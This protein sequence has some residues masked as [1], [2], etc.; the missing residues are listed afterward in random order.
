MVA[1]CAA[2]SSSSRRTVSSSSSLA[3][4]RH[5]HHQQHV[6]HDLATT[7]NVFDAIDD[8]NDGVWFSSL[9]E[10]SSSLLSSSSSQQRRRSFLLRHATLA[11]AAV[12][13]TTTYSHHGLLPIQPALA[14][15]SSSSSTTTT[16]K[17]GGPSSLLGHAAPDFELPN[18]QGQII[19]L[20]TL[21]SSGTKWA[22]LYF[23]P[24]AFTTGCTLEARKF[25]EL[26]PQFTLANAIISGISVD[27]VSTNTEFCNSE[28]LDFYLLS[29]INNG[30]ISK[31]Y[32]TALSVPMI[33][34][35]ANRQTYIIDPK[36]VIR[37]IFSNVEGKILQHPQ[38][39]LDKLKELQSVI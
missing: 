6:H 30:N 18:T 25:Q 10:S 34:T 28:K 35:F 9:L 33:G 20:D 13:T 27:T 31:L 36:K 5:P 39:V 4:R 32:N 11:A 22:I 37:A 3:H 38:E 1:Y 15:T 29:D 2:F 8:D 24:A 23:Y 26:L 14:A 17:N 16:T 21:T 7:K 19:T 12:T